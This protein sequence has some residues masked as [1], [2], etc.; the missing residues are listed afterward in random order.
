M[1]G[2]V[3]TSWG[4]LHYEI[5]GSGDRTIILFHETGLDHSAFKNLVP[6]LAGDL[7]V[8]TFDLPGCGESD[9]PPAITTIEEYSSHLREGIDA[10]GLG[11]VSL[12][13]AHTGA[14]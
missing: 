5:T 2:Y 6:E 13:G 4:Q 10:L 14:Q 3:D 12:F 8:L 7:Q 1:R 11:R 9:P